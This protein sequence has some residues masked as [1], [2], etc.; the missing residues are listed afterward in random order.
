MNH[1]VQK[2]QNHRPPPPTCQSP[3]GQYFGR[4]HSGR[5]GP[6]QAGILEGDLQAGEGLRRR[7]RNRLNRALDYKRRDGALTVKQGIVFD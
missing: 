2:K 1:P 7:G 4:V 6:R 3:L 5:K